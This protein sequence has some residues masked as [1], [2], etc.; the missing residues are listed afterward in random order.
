MF[1]RRTNPGLRGA[2]SGLRGVNPGLRGASSGLQGVNPGLRGVNPSAP[3]AR[4]TTP[5]GQV[6]PPYASRPAG[7]RETAQDGVVRLVRHENIP[8][9]PAS[10]WSVRAGSGARIAHAKH[11]V[12]RSTEHSEL[13]ADWRQKRASKALWTAIGRWVRYIPVEGLRLGYGGC[14]FRATE[15]VDSGLRRGYG[16]C[17]FRDM[18]GVDSGLRRVWIQGYGGSTNHS[19]ALKGAP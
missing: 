16:G 4:G 6:S 19:K 9:H 5:A 7:E 12:R 15:G 2:S 17:G 11:K 10:D 18:E 13:R 3:A 14:G 1:S 8:A